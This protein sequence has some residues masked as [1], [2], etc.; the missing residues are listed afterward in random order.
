MREKLESLEI[1]M[2]FSYQQFVTLLMES[3]K[4]SDGDIQILKNFSKEFFKIINTLVRVFPES[5][6]ELMNE[7]IKKINNDLKTT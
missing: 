7:E 2:C 1:N 4:I 6:N 5:K 3:K